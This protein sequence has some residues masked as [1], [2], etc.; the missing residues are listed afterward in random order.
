MR[1]QGSTGPK[2]LCT[3]GPAAGGELKA[4]PGL[5]FSQD[6][7]LRDHTLSNGDADGRADQFRARL[8]VWL[9]ID[10]AGDRARRKV[11]VFAAR[12]G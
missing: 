3:A 12:S 8:V 10:D 4:P 5:S 11:P 9:P 1:L 2:W 7:T 6:G